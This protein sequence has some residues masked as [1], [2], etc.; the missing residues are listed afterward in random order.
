MRRRFPGRNLLRRRG[1]RAQREGDPANPLTRDELLQK[2][3]QCL[4]GIVTTAR[5]DGIVDAVERLEQLPDIRVLSEL[6]RA[7]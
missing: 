1:S 3:Y 4:D 6:L 2:C 7:A 5:I